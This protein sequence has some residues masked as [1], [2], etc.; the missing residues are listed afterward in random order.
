MTLRIEQVIFYGDRLAFAKDLDLD[1]AAV[2]P[3]TLPG[4]SLPQRLITKLG[5]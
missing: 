4:S 5:V 1:R 3:L 2:A